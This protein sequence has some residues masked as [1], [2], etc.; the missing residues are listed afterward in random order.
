MALRYRCENNGS[1]AGGGFF[2]IAAK[3]RGAFL[4][5]GMLHAMGLRGGGAALEEDRKSAM[6]TL[7]R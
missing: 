1:N 5:A 6:V 3:A 4:R 7:I 2:E